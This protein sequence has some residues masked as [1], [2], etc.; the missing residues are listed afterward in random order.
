MNSRWNIDG[1]LSMTEI[2]EE[3]A[4]FVS[5]KQK[6]LLD[7]VLTSAAAGVVLA[8]IAA[9]VAGDASMAVLAETLQIQIPLLALTAV[10]SI[11]AK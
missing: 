11:L 7:N 9:L 6:Q 5:E 1:P 10:A 4:E 3:F 8:N 2:P